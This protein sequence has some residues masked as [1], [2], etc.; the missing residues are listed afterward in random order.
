MANT[1]IYASPNQTSLSEVQKTMIAQLGA[2]HSYWRGEFGVQM[3]IKEGEETLRFVCKF[4]RRKVNIDL[5]YDW[6]SDLYKIKAL[7]VDAFTRY[8][9]KMGTPTDK[10]WAE[11]TAKATIYDAGDVFAEDLI[12]RFRDIASKVDE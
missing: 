11:A 3:I 12:D 8:V 6:G 10:E 4:G 2:M 9:V 7:D 1:A 5:V